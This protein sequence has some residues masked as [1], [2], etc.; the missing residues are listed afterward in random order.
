MCHVCGLETGISASDT[1]PSPEHAVVEGDNTAAGD[2]HNETMHEP[3]HGTGESETI[4]SREE[5][6]QTVNLEAVVRRFSD[7]TCN[8]LKSGTQLDYI[9]AFRLFADH[10]CLQEYTPRQLRGPKGNTLI[11]DFI[12]ANVPLK[13]RRWYVAALR[14]VWISAIDKAF[15]LDTRRDLGRLPTIERGTSPPDGTVR[16]WKM[17]LDN[18]R[19]PYLRLSWLLVSQFGLRPSHVCRLK[20][21]NVDSDKDGRPVAIHANGSDEGFKTCA[22]VAAA[23]P[24]EVSDAMVAWK[25]AYPEE[26]TPDKLILPRRSAKGKYGPPKEPEQGRRRSA[27]RS[28]NLLEITTAEFLDHWRRMQVKW[29]LP[30]LRPSGLRHWVAT[31]CRKVDM[32]K[33]ATAYLMGHD[34]AAGG[35]MRDWY[36]NPAVLEALDEQRMRLPEGPLGYLDPKLVL[37]DDVP[38][39]ALV[40]VKDYFQGKVATLDMVNRLEAIRLKSVEHRVIA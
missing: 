30:R 34:S 2:E 17:A 4:L 38:P 39:S 22:P 5:F 40:L 26:I 24:K 28:S 18:E 11:K 32:S 10:A 19:D 8:Q 7:R 3:R 25:F 15:P 23:L 33:P 37:V 9:R 27:K 21:R 36:D 29:G 1:I 16:E 31:V 12:L 6:D 20:W 14:T 13:S 35:A